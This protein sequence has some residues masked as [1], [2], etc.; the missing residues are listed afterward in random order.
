MRLA[1]GRRKESP[2][3]EK[4]SAHNFFFLEAG[5]GGFPEGEVWANVLS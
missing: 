3:L 5:G 2:R 1:F 4:L